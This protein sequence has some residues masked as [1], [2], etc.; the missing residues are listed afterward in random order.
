MSVPS[1]LKQHRATSIFFAASVLVCLSIAVWYLWMYPYGN[2]HH[3]CISNLGLALMNYAEQNGGFFPAGGTC[4]EASLSLLYYAGDNPG[5]GNL[6]GK[7]VR[8]KVAQKA[9]DTVGSLGPE[10]CDWHY[11][12]GLT[13]KDDHRLAL[14]WDKVGLGHFGQRLLGG[15]HEVLFV[16]ND[17]YIVTGENWPKFLDEQRELL[18]NLKRK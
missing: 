11:V 5:A 14:L 15:G 9:L 3:A 7:T 18:A 17:H 10:S 2:T 8:E 13:V 1:I 6:G 4:P 12:E 16:N